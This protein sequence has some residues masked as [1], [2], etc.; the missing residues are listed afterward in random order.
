MGEGSQD[1]KIRERVGTCT[2]RNPRECRENQA[3]KNSKKSWVKG[4]AA[5]FPGG[6][7]LMRLIVAKERLEH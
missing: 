7:Y 1:G 5:A 2:D 6:G 4:L 3:P